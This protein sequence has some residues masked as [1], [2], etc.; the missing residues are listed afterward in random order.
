MI[1][2]VLQA[3]P[4]VTWQL[5]WTFTGKKRVLAGSASIGLQRSFLG[6]WAE[7]PVW[8]ERELSKTINESDSNPKLS[9]SY[10]LESGSYQ[11]ILKL[12]SSS[13][14]EKGR[15]LREKEKRRGEKRNHTK[16]RGTRWSL[17]GGM[18]KS[19]AKRGKSLS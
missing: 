4:G 12:I 17:R 10:L 19:L 1:I 9:K 18:K 11:M 8:S 13:K 7:E 15:N 16:K 14:I 6:Y 2:R 3:S 5:N